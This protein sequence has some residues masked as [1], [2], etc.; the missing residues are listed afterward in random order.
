MKSLLLTIALAVSATYAGITRISNGE[1]AKLGQ[2]PYQAFLQLNNEEGKIFRC[3]GSIIDKNWIVT[4]A[5]CTIGMAGAYVI[6]GMVQV[7]NKTQGTK[8]VSDK[9]VTNE[10]FDHATLENDVALLHFPQDIQFNE[11]VAP[12]NLPTDKNEDLVGKKF[13]VSGYGHLGR[14]KPKANTLQYTELSVLD[15]SKCEKIYNHEKFDGTKICAKGEGGK[16]TCGGDSGGPL[17]K[18]EKDNKTLMGLV[19]FGKGS[20][21]GH[22]PEGFTK[23][24]EYTDWIKGKMAN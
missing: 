6:V 13:I 14:D 12:I 23:V 19:S 2:F 1:D 10:N 3:G 20:C 17:A 24:V 15:D 7:D 18:Y 22:N 9:L 4:A 5:H 11:N 21:E 8:Y 16:S